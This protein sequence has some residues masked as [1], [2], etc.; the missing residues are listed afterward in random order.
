M[1]DD[2]K[3]GKKYLNNEELDLDTCDIEKLRELKQKLEDRKDELK[4]K[5]LG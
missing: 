2:E 1:F 4:G 3:W 5:I